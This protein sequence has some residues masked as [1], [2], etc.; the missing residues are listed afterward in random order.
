MLIH[1]ISLQRKQ[2]LDRDW[3]HVCHGRTQPQA[4]FQLA[5]RD[6]LHLLPANVTLLPTKISFLDFA[7]LQRPAVANAHEI[8]SVLRTLPAV[9]CGV[10]V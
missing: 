1:P 4:Y 3:L 6:L 7:T 10:H 9:G 5:A 2:S 8:G